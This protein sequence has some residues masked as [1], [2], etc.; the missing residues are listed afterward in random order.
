MKRFTASF[1]IF[2]LCALPAPAAPPVISNVSAT[3]R[4]GTK[5]VDVTYD[6][7]DPDSGAGP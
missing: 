7:A 4:A 2:S 6:V 1:L 5:L 3:Q